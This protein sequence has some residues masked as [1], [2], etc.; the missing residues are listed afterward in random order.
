MRARESSRPPAQR[1][2]R[3]GRLATWAVALLALV[4]TGCKTELYTGLDEREA[5]EMIAL[6]IKNGIDATRVRA[7]DGSSSLHVGESRFAEAVDLLKTNGYPRERFANLGEVFKTSGLI[8]SPTE[9]RARF[10]YALSQELSRTINDIDGVITAR[11]HVVLPKNDLLR[12]D[13][14]LSS[15]SVFVRHDAGVPLKQLLPQIKMLVANSIEGLAYEKVSV[16]FV[17]VVRAA[18]ANGT[19]VRQTEDRD[20]VTTGDTGAADTSLAESQAA[21]TRQAR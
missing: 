9:E 3:M 11:I 16:V 4:L 7:K 1:H 18:P 21:G 12:Q 2:G 10:I 13:V 6:L 14:T 19:A 15:A 5:N 8:A 17:P 20:R